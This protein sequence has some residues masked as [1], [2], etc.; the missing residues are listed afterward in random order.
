MSF[1]LLVLSSFGF[2]LTKVYG[3]LAPYRDSGDLAVSAVTLGIAHPP[4]YAFYT[5]LTHAGLQILRFGN[6][7]YQVNLLSCLWTALAVAV[8][9][10]TLKRSFNELS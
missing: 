10:S 5:L 3:T 8:L 9:F 6:R 4:G 2:L 7:A 1:S